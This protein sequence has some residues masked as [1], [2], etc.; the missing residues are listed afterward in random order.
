M[1]D[2]L[3]YIRVSSEEQADSGLGLEAQRQRIATYCAMKGLRLAEVFADPG[4]SGGKPL[5]SRPA[6]SQ[7]LAVAL[8]NNTPVIVAKLDRLFRSVADAAN[9]IADFEK[10]GIQ[11]VAIAESFDM[12]SP[13]GRAMAQM[14]SV[15]AELERAM[16]RERT[17]SAMKVKRSRGERI[18]GHAPCGWDFGSDGRLVE[19]SRE[20]KGIARMRELYA[21]GSS[22]RGIATLLEAEGILPK[23]GK[24]WAHTT[25]KSILTRKTS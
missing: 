7:L 13:Y 11:L 8:K 12:C 24:R 5:A 25:V 20:Q 16:I 14:A 6:G 1:E 23:R 19:N 3:G 9:V 15:F 22:Y 4:I 10:K 17:L 2:A 21:D 18:S